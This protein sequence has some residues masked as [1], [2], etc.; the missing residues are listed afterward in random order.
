MKLSYAKGLSFGVASGIVTTLGLMVGLYSGTHSK[1]AVLGGILTIAIADAMSDAFGMHLSEESSEHNEHPEIWESMIATFFAKL[2]IALTFALPVILLD[3]T[4]AIYVSCVWA[5]LL[6]GGI[7]IL[8]AKWRKE[9][10]V[11]A[12]LEHWGIAT[13]VVIIS[14]YVGVLIDKFFGNI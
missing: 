9:S 3:L 11:H 1:L 8:I 13:A 7:S 5:L 10:K 14:F 6:L 2:I 12:I 4:S